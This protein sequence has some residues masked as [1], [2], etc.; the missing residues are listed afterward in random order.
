[1]PYVLVGVQNKKRNFLDLRKLFTKIL[2]DT[3]IC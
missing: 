3:Y 1:M 2:E